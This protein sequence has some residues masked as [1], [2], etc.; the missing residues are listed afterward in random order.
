MKKIIFSNLKQKVITLMLILMIFAIPTLTTHAL[1]YPNDYYN[2]ISFTWTYNAPYTTSYN[3][4][5]YA[6]GSMTWEWPW[7]YNPKSIEVDYYLSTK[8]HS[9]IGPYT[10]GKTYGIMSYGPSLSTITHFAKSPAP[11]SIMGVNRSVAKWGG[12]ERFT[13]ESADPYYTSSSYSD[14]RTMYK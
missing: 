8:G 5:G 6:T 2:K 3:C 11:N 14:A 10:A 4:L 9:Y 1:Y 7:I 13:H 12:L